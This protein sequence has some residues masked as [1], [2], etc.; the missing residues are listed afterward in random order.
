[1][2]ILPFQNSVLAHVEHPKDSGDIGLNEKLGQFIP[3]DS[4]FNDERG[5]KVLLEDLVKAPTILALVYYHCP[6]V[7]SLLLTNLAGV[8]NKVPVEPGK[9]YRVIAVSFDEKETPELALERKRIYLQMI[10]RPFPENAWRFLTGE[11][12][13]IQ[14]LTQAVGFHFRKEGEDFLHP[15]SLVILAS[16]GKIVR[17]LNGTDFLPF[18]LQMA[19]LEASEGRVGTTINRVLRFCFSYDPKGRT[20][21]FNTLKVTGIVTLLFAFSFILFLFLKTKKDKSK[22][23]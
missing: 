18:D 15:V 11:R 19:L 1:M 21:V 16:D 6:N 17:Y 10:G 8:L 2:T 23:R 13:G 20:Y 7:C 14:K 3:L 5:N 9:E 12:E 22:E 4:T